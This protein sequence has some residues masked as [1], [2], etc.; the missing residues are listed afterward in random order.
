M[1]YLR[2]LKLSNAAAGKSTSSSSSRRAMTDMLYISSSW[3][4]L[5]M[6]RD[7]EWRPAVSDV[8]ECTAR[9][10]EE[11]GAWL[12]MRRNREARVVSMPW[13]GMNSCDDVWIVSMYLIMRGFSCMIF[14]SW[15]MRSVV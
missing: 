3:D 7:G 14:M 11:L 8:R 2:R 4:M 9:N 6:G 12:L 13:M 15:K 1:T 10:S 5:F